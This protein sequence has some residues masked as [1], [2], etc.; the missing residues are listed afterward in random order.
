MTVVALGILTG[1]YRLAWAP[2][3]PMP[4]PVGPSDPVPGCFVC[5]CVSAAHAALRGVVLFEHI[6]TRGHITV[7]FELHRNLFVIDRYFRLY[8]LKAMMHA[9][10]QAT[11]VALQQMFI[12]GTL[13]D[14]KHQ[15]E[16]QRVFDKL[17][18]EAHRDY[19][20]SMDMC[21]FGTQARGLAAAQR[22]GQTVAHIMSQRF[23]D[24]QLHNNNANA[25]EGRKEDNEGRMYLFFTHYCD[26][27]DNNDRL[28]E[29]CETPGFLAAN[30]NQTSNKDIDYG[31]MIES[32]LTVNVMYPDG[33]AFAGGLEG[34]DIFELAS[35][36]YGHET[37]EPPTPEY[38]QALPN[39]PLY[40]DAR[41]IAAK[42]SVAQNSFSTIAGMRSL[43]SQETLT[44]RGYT[45]IVMNQLGLEEEEDIEQL[46]GRRPS[47]HSQMEVLTK[48]LYQRPEFYTNLYDTEANIARKQ[49]SMRAIGL[50]QNFDMFKSRLRNE[51]MLAVL[52][53]AELAAEQ[54]RLMD[55][56]GDPAEEG[57]RE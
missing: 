56:H 7:E 41:A 38:M 49:A 48:T 42:R 24:R 26:V 19:Q 18:A 14:A 37:S 9:T 36:L 12:L 21:V 27:H 43:G 1:A 5:G 28:Q 6:G 33:T 31:R 55:L 35:N 44:T 40:L 50:M 51:A 46:L 57:R 52:L 22:R 3:N 10:Q 34:G 15:L 17:K 20:P 39:R 47:Y 11:S 54:Q 53:E 4:I 13:F 2:P 30:Q 23:L 8:L 25:A 32:R 16:T 45:T 29:L